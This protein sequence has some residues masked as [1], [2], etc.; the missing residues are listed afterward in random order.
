MLSYH[1]VVRVWKDPSNPL[2]VDYKTRILRLVITKSYVVCNTPRVMWIVR[3][4]F[5]MGCKPRIL[6]LVSPE[7]CGVSAMNSGDCGTRVT[8]DCEARIMWL[9]SLELGG[10]SAQDS[11]DYKR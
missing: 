4:E 10:L 9:V 1:L 5:C 7:F 2:N 11:V 8:M 6:W 3:P